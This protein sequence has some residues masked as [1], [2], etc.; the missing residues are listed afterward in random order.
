M[1][2]G[3]HDACAQE[4]MLLV[5]IL[6]C[7]TTREAINWTSLDTSAAVTDSICHFCPRDL[8][9]AVWLHANVLLSF[10]FPCL[11][12]PPRVWYVFYDTPFEIPKRD[13][14]LLGSCPSLQWPP[15]HNLAFKQQHFLFPQ[16]PYCYVQKLATK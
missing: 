13:W 4:K 10:Y 6:F 15:F 9:K 8:D 2:M 7:I 11:K 1:S 12:N 14:Y 5:A 3:R 16:S